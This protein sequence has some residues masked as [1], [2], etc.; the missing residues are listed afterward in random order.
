MGVREKMISDAN[1]GIDHHMRQQ[2]RRIANLHV[3][4]DHGVRA[5][6]AIAT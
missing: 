1:V 5:H 4:F 3:G 6:M 2:H